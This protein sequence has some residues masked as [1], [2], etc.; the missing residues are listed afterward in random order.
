MRIKFLG[1]DIMGFC[2]DRE[3]ARRPSKKGFNYMIPFAE[4]VDGVTLPTKGQ[5]KS[6]MPEGI[7]IHY[8]AGRFTW[9]AR[10]FM[11][12][13]R[14]QGYATLYIDGKGR[15]WQNHDLDRWGNHAGTSKCPVT[16]RASVSRYYIGIEVAC[17]GLVDKNGKAWFGKTYDYNEFSSQGNIQGGNY[18]S[19]KEQQHHMLTKTCVH[20]MNEFSIPETM[21]FGHDEIS[22]NRKQ[23]PGGSLGVTMETYRKHLAKARNA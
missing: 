7:I 10:D 5:Y 3:A 4:S 6:G 11:S 20:L 15:L 13:M 23:D 8:T 21:V 17:P 2:K 9:S 1:R 22:P 16:G 12:W 19:F 14:S 18:V